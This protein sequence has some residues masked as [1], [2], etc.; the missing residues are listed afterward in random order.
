MHLED[1]VALKPIVLGFDGS[2][3]SELALDWALGAARGRGT[4]VRIVQAWRSFVE[5]WPAF[6]GY[7]DPDPSLLIT[8]AEETLAAALA[9]AH[10]TAPQ[11][12]VE[13]HLVNGGAA[14]ALIEE[15]SQAEIVVVGSRG[16]GGFGELMLGST[17][18]EVAAHAHCPVVVIRPDTSDVAPGAE[19]G[20]V[21]VGVDGSVLSIDALAF[22]FGEAFLRARGL[23]AVHA[24][25]RPSYDAPGKGAPIAASVGDTVFRGPELQALRDALATWREKLPAV[26]VREA[27]RDANPAAALIAASAGAELLVVGSR[28]RGGFASLVL[29][30]VSHAVLH[31]AHCPV[32]VVRPIGTKDP[33]RT[34]GSG[35]D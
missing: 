33:H 18:V 9:T 10:R 13:T 14:A 17:A 21:V 16:L 1:A 20:R 29:G 5:P 34:A 19:A 27:V 22:A 35:P 25:H 28:G 15:S 2:E 31:H 11:I 32:A 30:S 26:D 6:G 23:T 3:G 12:P 7:A 8:A 24:W 4:S